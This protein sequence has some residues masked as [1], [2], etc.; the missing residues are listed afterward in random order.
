ML[1]HETNKELERR[2]IIK[3][4]KKGTYQGSVCFFVANLTTLNTPEGTA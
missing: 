3:I 2:Q 4:K 1:N